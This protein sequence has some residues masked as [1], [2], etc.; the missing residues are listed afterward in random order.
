MRTTRCERGSGVAGLKKFERITDK[1]QAQFHCFITSL[2]IFCSGHSCSPQVVSSIN[3]INFINRKVGRVN[4]RYELRLEW[5]VDSTKAV[6]VNS[7]FVT[8]LLCKAQVVSRGIGKYLN[9][10][11]NK[12]VDKGYHEIRAVVVLHYFYH[13]WRLWDFK[14]PDRSSRVTTN[15]KKIKTSV[16]RAAYKI[17][18]TLGR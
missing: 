10:V 7:T 16:Q 18:S 4:I 13:S 14:Q 8:P 17:Q 5:S 15:A 11:Q 6:K 12:Y 3:L 2:S 9:T 1:W